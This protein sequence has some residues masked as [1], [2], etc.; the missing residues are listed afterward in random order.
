[1]KFS[2]PKSLAFI[3]S[4]V[5]V[6]FCSLI[7]I[8]LGLIY[9]HIF[10]FYMVVSDIIIFIAAYF[11]YLFFIQKFINEKIKLIYKTIQNS[12]SI[13]YDKGWKYSLNGNI[14]DE[15]NRDVMQW[16]QESSREIEELKKLEVYRREF[17]GNI[18]HELKTPIFNIQGYILTLLE[19]GLEDRNIN[20]RYLERAENS[21]NRMITIVRDLETISH[22]ESGEIE[23]KYEK[24]DIVTLTKEVFEFLE[25][26]AKKKNI[27][28]HFDRSY[29]SVYVEADKDRIR[30]VL[31]NLID[32]SINYGNN[33][34]ESRVSFS[35]LADNI[36]IEVADN[37]IG[38]AQHHIPRLFERFYRTDKGRSREEGGSGLGLAIVKHIIESHKHSISVI[39]EAG[40]GS[41]FTFTLQK[42]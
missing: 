11:I 21:I 2:G 22:L 32:N 4:S 29:D 7:Y 23:M 18:S 39:S 10:W 15:V 27:K 30:Q 12:R 17:I 28:L 38:I 19:G 41:I 36:V 13:K 5:I 25:I 33:D 40:K 1:M 34:G 14:L 9:H 24:F 6:V 42:G 35:E 26:K 16:A 8:I 20:R 37:G 31:T 3:I